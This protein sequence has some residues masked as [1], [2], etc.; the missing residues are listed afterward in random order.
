MGGDVAEPACVAVGGEGLRRN[1]PGLRHP[2]RV[3]P[4]G[5]VGEVGEPEGAE[6]V[7]V[8]VEETAEMGDRG[9]RTEGYRV[10]SRR[11][12]RKDAGCGGVRNEAVLLLA[13]SQVRN[14]QHVEEEPARQLSRPGLGHFPGASPQ[15]F[16]LDDRF[17]GEA[18][19]KQLRTQSE[20]GGDFRLGPRAP[21]KRVGQLLPQPAGPLG[22]QVLVPGRVGG[23]GEIFEHGRHLQV[24]CRQ[25]PAGRRTCCPEQHRQ[26]GKQEPEDVDGSGSGR[27]R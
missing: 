16:E 23:G 20:A 7:R 1:Q 21:G 5:H 26:G 2:V 13:E 9:A 6:I 25:G 27:M 19:A 18:G 24:G 10:H 4:E 12:Y 8:V 15:A 14:S 17:F 11:R 22:V 3:L